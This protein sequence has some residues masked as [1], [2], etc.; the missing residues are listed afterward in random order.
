MTH[1]VPEMTRI[2]DHVAAEI[3]DSRAVYISGV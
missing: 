3:A 1:P 2:V